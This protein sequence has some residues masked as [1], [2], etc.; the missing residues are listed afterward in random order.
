MCMKR[1]AATDEA[2]TKRVIRVWQDTVSTIR[3]DKNKPF[4][5]IEEYIDFRLVDGGGAYV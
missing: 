1:L 5:S 3:Q 2:C 4:G